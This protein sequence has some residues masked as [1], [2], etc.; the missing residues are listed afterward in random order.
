MSNLKIGKRKLGVM[1]LSLMLVFASACTS[2]PEKTTSETPSATE[3][4]TATESPAPTEIPKM[5][6][7][8][9]YDTPIEVTTASIVYPTTTYPEGDSLDSNVWTKLYEEK[10]G[11]KTKHIWTAP[12]EQYQAKMTASIASN[13]IPDI[14]LVDEIF[15][16]AVYG[17]WR[18]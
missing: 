14:M 8:G 5:D 12:E 11:I 7:L 3:T 2:K 15:F 1:L 10:L 6:P 9:K 13:D 18:S 4:A 16:Q 17:F